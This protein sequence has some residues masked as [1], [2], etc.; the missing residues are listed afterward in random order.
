MMKE[1][2]EATEGNKIDLSGGL[3]ITSMT[4]EERDKR[5]AELE[6]KRRN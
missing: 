1:I 5:I 3:D 6:A 4:P 2:R